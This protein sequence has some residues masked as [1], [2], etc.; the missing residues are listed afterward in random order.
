VAGPRKEGWRIAQNDGK[1]ERLGVWA[2]PSLLPLLK[3]KKA[4]PQPQQSRALSSR[5]PVTML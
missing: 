1:I 2:Y 3:K 4:D 5:F